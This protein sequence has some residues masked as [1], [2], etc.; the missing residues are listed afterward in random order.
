MHWYKLT[1]LPFAAAQII[2]GDST[3]TLAF[4]NVTVVDDDQLWVSSMDGYGIKAS[5]LR[6]MTSIEA[7]A[8]DYRWPF[9]PEVSGSGDSGLAGW[10]VAVIVVVSVLGAVAL[11]VLG[12][13]VLRRRALASG[14]PEQDAELGV[15]DKPPESPKCPCPPTHLRKLSDVLLR[16]LGGSG[17]GNLMTTNSSS[18]NARITVETGPSSV[19]ASSRSK[20]YDVEAGPDSD[21]QRGS[22]GQRS[23]RRN[24]N[25]QKGIAEDTPFGGDAGAAAAA[26][27]IGSSGRAGA[28]VAS[29]DMAVQH[30][31][32]SLIEHT[33]RR[34]NKAISNVSQDLQRRRVEAMLPGQQASSSTQ[35]S[36]LERAS[37]TAPAASG[38][39][40]SSSNPARQSS[41]GSGTVG[42]SSTIQQLQLFEVLGNGNFGAVYRGLWRGTPVAVKVMQLPASSLG[43]MQSDVLAQQHLQQAAMAAAAG[44]GGALPVKPVREHMAVREAAISISAA[45]SHPNIVSGGRRAT[46]STAAG[47][48]AAAAAAAAAGN[49]CWAGCMQ[50][51]FRR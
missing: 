33:W 22:G 51:H 18:G 24:S 20:S 13:I 1:R 6:L 41:Q 17:S 43:N 49:V 35:R 8:A 31:G 14:P 29:D 26:A 7:P 23:A 3:S 27:A 10:L 19:S 12:L 16:P 50:V 21:R 36:S 28:S 39:L 46:G 48:A 32:P 4:I 34:L 37:S 25:V 47:A 5:R 38:S 30:S 45:V 15:D 2:A 40:S 42:S 9:D 11:A 44:G